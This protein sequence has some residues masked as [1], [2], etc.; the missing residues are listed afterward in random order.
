VPNSSSTPKL[1]HE[2]FLG[3][4]IGV[5]KSYPA[6][7]AGHGVYYWFQWS[8]VLHEQEVLEQNASQVPT[9]RAKAPE[10]NAICLTLLPRAPMPPC[11]HH[12]TDALCPTGDPW[13]HFI[14][15]PDWRSMASLHHSAR[16]ASHGLITSLCTTG[17]PWPHY[18]TL[19]DWRP[20]A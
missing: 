3:L 19:P 1:K 2:S 11:Q 12:I 7:R 5:Q 15:L 14:T 8:P 4:P 10:N 17:D 9:T 6:C 13:P 18:I 20:M 16:L